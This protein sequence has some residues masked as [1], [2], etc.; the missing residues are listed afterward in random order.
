M[1]KTDSILGS[2]ED[3]RHW[4]YVEGELPAA[5]PLAWGAI[6]LVGH[7]RTLQAVPLLDEL[8]KLQ[9]ADGA[10]GIYEGQAAPHWGTSLAVLA[11][12]AA[13]KSV[14]PPQPDAAERY[15]AAIVQGCRFLLELKGATIKP[16]GEVT[17]NTM[18]VGWPWVEST[19]SWLEP[20]AFCF[21]ALK[22][23]GMRAH[24]RAEEA[25]QLMID[26]ILPGGGCNYGNTIVLDQVLR[27]HIQPTGI[28]MLALA[29]DADRNE[30]VLKSIAWLEQSIDERTTIASLA[31]AAMGLAAHDH[32][33]VDILSRLDIALAKPTATMG[34]ALPRRSLAALAMLGAR[35]PLVVMSREGAA[36]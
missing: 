24:P 9:A 17:H 3:S 27:P 10:V 36:R 21:L 25:V 8:C 29:G 16:S 32:S 2:L 12:S 7:E 1:I 15:R 5:E 6:A 19:H 33:P 34:A 18:L 4:G 28:V 26:R 14:K 30:R 31:F 20:T 35:S 13:L 23:A 22:A 11:W